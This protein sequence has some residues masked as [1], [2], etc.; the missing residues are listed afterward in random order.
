MAKALL[1]AVLTSMPAVAFGPATS[2]F[3]AS[4][5]G[6]R[7]HTGTR[8]VLQ[9]QTGWVQPGGTFSLRIGASGAGSLTGLDVS[10]SVFPPVVTRSELS[11]VFG[12]QEQA[13]QLASS[14]PVP[15]R[16]LATR[17]GSVQIRVGVGSR[18]GSGAAPLVDV[19]ALPPCG[20]VC[21]GVY[22]L[23][24][25]F[26][27]PGSGAVVASLTTEMLVSRPAYYPLHFSWVV[28][29]SSP[30]AVG[31]TGVPT[32]TVSDMRLLS[33]EAAALGSAAGGSPVLAPDPSTL[34]ALSARASSHSAVAASLL[35]RLSQIAN[36]PGQQVLGQALEMLGP[37][38]FARAR[39]GPSFTTQLSLGLRTEKSALRTIPSVSTWVSG[40]EFRQEGLP[41]LPRATTSLV[42]TPN[43]LVSHSSNLTPDH[44]F[45]V[46]GKARLHAVVSD[47]GL[48][49]LL[50]KRA[51]DSVL[52]AHEALATLAQTYFESPN[53]PVP[54][55]VVLVVP[56]SWRSRPTFI[57]SFARGLASSP[58]VSTVNLSTLFSL[59]RPPPA[60]AARHLRRS[61]HPSSSLRGGVA[62][63][64]RRLQALS[65]M[66]AAPTQ[67][68]DMQDC[69]A[70]AESPRASPSSR[71]S[72]LAT[73]ARLERSMVGGMAIASDQT[74]TLT[75][76]TGR[77]PL[78]I[79][80]SYGKPL[81]AIVT[82]YSDKLTF[83]AGRS[84]TVRLLDHNATVTFL[85]SARTAGDSPLRVRVFS[86]KGHLLVIERRLTVR[87]TAVSVVAVVLTVG[88]V[89]FLLLWWLR[90]VV[91]GRRS[92]N[93]NLMP[94]GG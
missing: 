35:R 45:A 76:R 8:P 85:V 74:V 18:A 92:R 34:S 27:R 80:S 66:T 68:L 11:L 12:G 77:L 36:R 30:P 31:P 6:S 86:P 15:A 3:G 89:S 72:S 1:V 38:P 39:L 84:Q 82:L 49:S 65:S 58:V 28:P 60:S 79:T 87:V 75:A 44:A 13:P 81:Q 61:Q 59:L 25:Q 83:P 93:R 16:Q 63:A 71:R 20:G 67:L 26:T 47:P 56:P 64:Q 2:A 57:A 19:P 91:R 62:R 70:V 94:A 14:A 90:S 43:D 5:K 22:P 37:S 33:S 9:S 52:A 50:P 69:M 53:D 4:P 48:A 55:G 73:L 40:P 46:A 51:H 54:R 78:T 41:L 24:V 17:S 29:I 21:A 23:L 42:L 10:A 7:S 32:V 88:A